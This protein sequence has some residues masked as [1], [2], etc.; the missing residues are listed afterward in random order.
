MKKSKAFFSVEDHADL[1]EAGI[2]SSVGHIAKPQDV[3]KPM[4]A[5]LGQGFGQGAGGGGGK[6]DHA[7]GKKGDLYGDQYVLLR[8]VDPTDGGGNGEPVLDANGQQ[9]LVGSNGS[10][11]HYVYDAST[12]DYV[13]PVDQLG[14]VQTVELG[15]ANVARA[16][17]KVMEKS[18]DEALS[19]VMSA[20]ELTTDVAGRL[21]CDGV[22][23][24][25]PLE[26]LALYRYL[27]TAG[28]DHAWPDVKAN[29]PAPIASLDG[30]DPSSLLGAAFD[31]SMP[32]S[33]DAVLY[34]NTT[35]GVN[36][37]DIKSTAYFDFTN[38]NTE[39]YNHSRED[40]WSDIYVQW[41]EDVDADGD[42]EL[43][44]PTSVYEA[45]FNG[46]EW[47][48]QYLNADGMVV[49]AG[50]SGVNDFA[51]AVDDARA[52]ISFMH[53][54]LGAVE[55]S[56]PVPVLMSAIP[57]NSEL[58]PVG[59]G[60][61][62]IETILGSNQADW[63]IATGGSQIIE[64]GNGKDHVN[65]GGGR[66][67]IMGGNG[68]DHLYGEGGPDH[69]DGGNGP[70]V[71][72]GGGGSDEL[73]GGHGPDIFLFEAHDDGGAD[74]HTGGHGE[75]SKDAPVIEA[76]FGHQDSIQGSS[77]VITDFEPGIDKIDLSALGVSLH[78]SAAPEALG[79]WVT[80]QEGNT[81]VHADTNGV[82]SGSDGAEFHVM[83]LGIQAPDI[84]AGDFVV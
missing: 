66:D 54:K 2:P 44:E 20:D 14:L 71:L 59:E 40:R 57:V 36:L 1:L 11:I 24:D 26:N 58:M 28:G 81:I 39:S 13:I 34:E 49:S 21:V 48:D 6:P 72:V 65:A 19:K 84:T 73:T 53:D 33:M 17:E 46:Q 22:T 27:M 69:I 3:M 50:Q 4:A 83:L 32:I 78:W 56:A 23:I 16:P 82:V 76:L 70:D 41:Y 35:L 55:V 67:T 79:I 51:Q 52:V 68:A 62:Q 18:L 29:W 38:G 37:F 60:E 5:G 9:I 10:L 15:R 77:D 75:Y 47:N 63:I 31:K 25:S 61:H 43:V 30:W 74:G 64:A 12:G 7:G 45:V 80:Q 8:D 42:L